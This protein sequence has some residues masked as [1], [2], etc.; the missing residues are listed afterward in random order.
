MARSIRE[1]NTKRWRVFSQC[2]VSARI[3]R[4]SQLHHQSLQ[5]Q[6]QQTYTRDRRAPLWQSSPDIHSTYYPNTYY[7]KIVLLCQLPLLLFIYFGLG[8]RHRRHFEN[9]PRAA[10]AKRPTD[11]YK[12]K[13]TQ[14]AKNKSTPEPQPTNQQHNGPDTYNTRLP[15]PSTAAP[16]PRGS[17]RRQHQQ[18]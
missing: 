11:I 18:R 6:P 4:T 14:R 13:T 16:S 5:A 17:T 15:C 10:G 7:T 2:N 1:S 12:R 9:P 8:Q 3:D